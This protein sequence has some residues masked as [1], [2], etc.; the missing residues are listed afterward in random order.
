MRQDVIRWDEFAS[1]DAADKCLASGYETLQAVV[2]IIVL[3]I[4]MILNEHRQGLRWGKFEQAKRFSYH[5]MDV[6]YCALENLEW[7]LHLSATLTR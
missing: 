2:M 3:I 7:S 5:C 1:S 4:V 6:F